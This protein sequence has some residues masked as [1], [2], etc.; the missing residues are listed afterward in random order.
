MSDLTI[1]AGGIDSTIHRT[2]LK[3][4]QGPHGVDKGAVISVKPTLYIAGETATD[5]V[6]FLSTEVPNAVLRKGG[7]SKLIGVTMIDYENQKI[8]WDLWFQRVDSDFGTLGT[9]APTISDA[10]LKLAKILGAFDI[11]WSKG[12]VSLGSIIAT[13]QVNYIQSGATQKPTMPIMLQAESNSTSIYVQGISRGAI[14]W[15]A[16]DSLELIIYVEYL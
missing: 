3:G 15:A 10:N 1:T 9:G 8:N 12:V 2:E 6:M 5:K 4:A 16:A 14:T 7:A 11:D 13:K